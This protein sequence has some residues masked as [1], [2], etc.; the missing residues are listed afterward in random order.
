MRWLRPFPLAAL[1]FMLLLLWDASG[2]DLPLAQAMGTPAGFPW[3]DNWFLVNVMHQ[4]GRA[5]GW[6]LFAALLV[7]IPRPFGALR[8]LGRRDRAQIVIAALASVAL[9]TVFKSANSTSCPWALRDF[10]GAA[11][12]VSHWSW[13]MRDGGGGHC[14]PAGHASAAF[15]YLGGY[16]AWRRAAPSIAWQWLLGAA[17]AGVA[18]G[19]APQWRGAPVKSHTLWTAWLCWTA[20]YLVDI[21]M[22]WRDRRRGPRADEL[23]VESA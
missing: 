9:V 1:F 13:G 15:A 11:R 7:A 19:L 5:A 6:A 8:R 17:R 21:G 20:G 18:R 12:Y 3:R 4:G 16:F 10:G 2:L 22:R 23:A 14:F